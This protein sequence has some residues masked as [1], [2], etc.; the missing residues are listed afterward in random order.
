MSDRKTWATF[1]YTRLHGYLLAEA[2]HAVGRAEPRTDVPKLDRAALTAIVLSA[3]A[4]EAAVNHCIAKAFPPVDAMRDR[5]PTM[6]LAWTAVDNAGSPKKKLAR[7]ALFLECTFDAGAEPWMSAGDLARLRNRL[8]HYDARPVITSEVGAVPP[9]KDLRS[10]AERLRLID[11]HA[12]HGGTWLDVFVNRDG[13]QWALDTAKAVADTLD[14][15]PWN[16]AAR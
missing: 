11:V 2:S 5:N 1:Q 15:A 4:V 8:V 7:L 13:A 12:K 9:S 10:L 3:A 6:W 14:A 16:R